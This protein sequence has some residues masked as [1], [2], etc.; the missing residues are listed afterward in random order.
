VGRLKWWFG[1]RGVDVKEVDSYEVKSVGSLIVPESLTNK[2]A[3]ILANSVAEMYF[4][5]DFYADRI[6]KLRFFIANKAGREIVNSELNRFVSDSINPLFSFS[7]L[8][9]QYVFS[10]YSDGNAINYLGVPSIYNKPS[11]STIERWDV[12]Q[13]N[14]FEIDE[15]SNQSILNISSWNDMIRKAYYCDGSNGRGELDVDNLV[16]NNYGLKRRSDSNVLASSPMWGANKSIDVLLSVYSA[17]YNV[18][19]N[20]GAAGY[21]AKKQSASSGT[22]LDTAI[23]NMDGSKRDDIINDINERNGLTGRRNIWGISG[24]PIEFVKTLASIRDLMP[25]DETLENAVKIASVFQIPPVLVPRKDQSTYDNQ[26]NAE[27]NVWE[28]A[29]LSAAKTIS[30]NLTKMFGI[31]KTGN[32]ILFD[33]S[34]VSALVENEIESEDLTAKKLENIKKLKEIKP[35]LE[36]DN[37]ITEI[38]SRYGNEK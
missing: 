3:F 16:I 22:S 9:Y 7:D 13:P 12:L 1:K 6:S 10:L 28:N 26:E 11:V 33:I 31:D 36:I 35:E 15:Y 37:I 27:A 5:V 8:V 18:Y 4:P 25:L 24:V 34:S 20:N 2:N 30:G 32:Q 38:H 23:A 19:A 21:L 29:L 17:R 14:L